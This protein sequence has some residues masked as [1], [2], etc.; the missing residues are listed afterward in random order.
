MERY[1]ARYPDFFGKFLESYE[2]VRSLHDAPRIFGMDQHPRLLEKR[3]QTW[4]LSV[5]FPQIVYRIDCESTF[6]SFRKTMMFDHQHKLRT[7]SSVRKFVTDSESRGGSYDLDDYGKVLFQMLSNHFRTTA[8][9]GTYY[10]LPFGLAKSKVQG[11]A[12]FIT[13]PQS[14]PAVREAPDTASAED[15]DG[16]DEDE[17]PA[18]ALDEDMVLA[19]PVPEQPTIFQVTSTSPGSKKQ[20]KLPVGVGRNLKSTDI[21][22][23]VFDNIGT[24]AVQPFASNSPRGPISDSVSII[25]DIGDPGVVQEHLLQWSADSALYTLPGSI[26]SCEEPELSEVVTTLIH[27]GAWPG[28]SMQSWPS[29]FDGMLLQCLDELAST[30]LVQIRHAADGAVHACST[31]KM[32]EQLLVH[33]RLEA[34]Q[35]IFFFFLAHPPPKSS[36]ASL[37]LSSQ[38][39]LVLFQTVF[40]AVAVAVASVVVVVIVAVVVVVGMWGCRCRCRRGQPRRVPRTRTW[41]VSS[42]SSLPTSPSSLLSSSWSSLPSSLPPLWSLPL[43]LSSLSSSRSAAQ[44]VVMVAVVVI[45]V[46]IVSVVVVCVV[47]IA[48]PPAWDM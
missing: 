33:W 3:H 20:I 18:P 29:F 23:T 44:G 21:T 31:S 48:T 17:A 16:R 22:I 34:P 15:D 41:P 25:S 14:R 46:V 19:E 2:S 5:I 4:E 24:S 37:V 27:S 32:A 47:S 45:L 7:R 26:T 11:L 28:S 12:D 43:L 6:R 13:A 38:S 39:W 35:V 42:L 36:F 9:Q 30:E 10:S 40:V 8:K 1:L